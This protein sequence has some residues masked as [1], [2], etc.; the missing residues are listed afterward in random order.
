MNCAGEWMDKSLIAPGRKVS[1]QSLTS[2]LTGQ[3]RSHM[4]GLALWTVSYRGHQGPA[5]EMVVGYSQRKSPT[6]DRRRGYYINTDIRISGYVLAL[7]VDGV[8]GNTL[9][10]KQITRNDWLHRKNRFQLERRC[11]LED[12]FKHSFLLIFAA[13]VTEQ[14]IEKSKTGVNVEPIFI[15]GPFLLRPT[16]SRHRHS[17]RWWLQF[18]W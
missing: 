16:I 14:L 13:S 7:L 10:W 9:L 15:F 5:F 1:R 18:S 8:Q 3:V 11:N 6:V 4:I 2:R 17:S 12:C